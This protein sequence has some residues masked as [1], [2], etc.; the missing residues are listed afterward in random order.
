MVNFQDQQQV[1]QG[2]VLQLNC[3][4]WPGSCALHKQHLL[5]LLLETEDRTLVLTQHGILFQSKG[6]LAELL[7]TSQCWRAVLLCKRDLWY[8]LCSYL[9]FFP[10]AAHCFD[11]GLALLIQH[12]RF[13]NFSLI[14][15]YTSILKCWLIPC[16]KPPFC[17]ILGVWLHNNYLGE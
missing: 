17:M 7:W 9:V 3:W 10:H 8:L 12:K 5:L 2:S 6:L 4:W 16:P 13:N 14:A 15:S 1:A 11:K